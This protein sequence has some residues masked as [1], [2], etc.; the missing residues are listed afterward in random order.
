M[1][2]SLVATAGASDANAYDTAANADIYF[3][4]H[5]DYE[6][7]DKL[8][9]SQKERYLIHAT[10]LI[11]AEPIDG[12]KYDTS[13]TS[14]AADQALRFPRALDYID[15]TLVI[16]EAAKITMFEQALSEAMTGTSSTRQDLQAEG[17]TSVKMAD[18]TETY[19]GR[20]APTEL[21]KRARSFLLN[22]GLL[23]LAGSWA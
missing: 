7:W 13:T 1:A 20:T 21:C 5:P 12:D 8:Y 9:T 17:V 19:G 11:D 10:T 15:S 14:G 23:K 18:I 4:A 2:L 6:T 16:P 22:A 3:T